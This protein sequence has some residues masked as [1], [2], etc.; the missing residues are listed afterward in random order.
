MTLQDRLEQE[1]RD[2]CGCGT[3]C[4]EPERRHELCDFVVFMREH[5]NIARIT[6]HHMGLHS[7]ASEVHTNE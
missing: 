4:W 1:A 6:L 5:A 2:R 3:C 7:A